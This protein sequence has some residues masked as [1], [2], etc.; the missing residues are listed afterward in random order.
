MYLIKNLSFQRSTRCHTRAQEATMGSEENISGP[1]VL[2]KWHPQQRV[3]RETAS[4]KVLREW[5]CLWNLGLGARTVWRESL[6]WSLGLLGQRSMGMMVWMNLEGYRESLGTWQ[7]NP[8]IPKEINPEYSSGGLMLELKLQSFGHLMLRAW[9]WERLR[10]GEGGDRR[11]YGWMASPTQWTWLW[12][13][14]R[15]V[16]RTG[17]PGMMQPMGLQRVRH[18]W[19]TEQQLDPQHPNT[20]LGLFNCLLIQDLTRLAREVGLDL[21]GAGGT[22]D[23]RQVTCEITWHHLSKEGPLGSQKA[24]DL[25]WIFKNRIS[26]PLPTLSREKCGLG[27]VRDDTLE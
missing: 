15:R 13:N 1:P 10:A 27:L 7:S 6:G 8:S 14:S 24:G 16:W 23:V 20:K 3:F 18:N 22:K 4:G 25:S 9:C 26:R 19:A 2:Q 17:K 12:T 5:W 11:W 21:Q